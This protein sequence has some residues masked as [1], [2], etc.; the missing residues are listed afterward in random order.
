MRSSGH[1]YCQGIAH[2]PSGI[3]LTTQHFWTDKLGAR[4]WPPRLAAST[5][6]RSWVAPGFPQ[7]H[8]RVREYLNY[9][10]E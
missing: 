8:N 4:C 10:E 3:S 9:T 6:A 1:L 5:Q 2:A 7:R